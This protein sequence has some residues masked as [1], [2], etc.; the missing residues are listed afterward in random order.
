MVEILVLAVLVLAVAGAAAAWLPGF[1]RR[2]L[3]AVRDDTAGQLAALRAETVAHDRQLSTITETLD[4]RLNSIDTKVDRRF[5]HASETS[6]QIHEQ[7]GRIGQTNEQMLER[8]KDLSRLQ[9]ALRPPKARG[10]FGEHLLGN[11]L[12]DTFPRDKYQLQYTFKSGE[13]VD[14]VIR[15]DRSLVP[16][17]AKFPLD[18]FQRLVEADADAQ[19]ELHAKQ[20][21]RDVKHHVDAIAQKY[22]R[23]D[24]GT[25]EFALMYLPAEAVYYELVCGRLGGES[26]PLA[27]ALERRVIPVSP[28]TLHAYLLVL[29]LGFKGMQIEEHARGHDVRGPA[30]AGLRP[31][32]RRLRRRRQAP[33]ERAVP[34]RGRRQAAREVRAPARAGGRVGDTAGAARSGAGTAPRSGRRLEPPRSARARRSPR[35]GRGRGGCERRRRCRRARASGA[36]RGRTPRRAPRAG[37][38]RAGTSRPRP[39]H[40]RTAD[41]ARP[42]VGLRRC[43]AAPRRVRPMRPRVS[44]PSRPRLDPGARA[45]RGTGRPA[46]P[47]RPRARA[48][49]PGSPRRAPREDP[50][51]PRRRPSRPKP[52]APPVRAGARTRGGPPQG[53]RSRPSFLSSRELAGRPPRRPRGSGRRRARRCAAGTAPATTRPGRDG[54]AALRSGRRPP[55]AGRPATG[56]GSPAPGSRPRPGRRRLVRRA[57]PA[58]RDRTRARP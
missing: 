17:D 4:R 8:A 53:R 25:Y 18:N 48:R 37:F 3:G 10:G 34:V 24:E 6:R 55:P 33:R 39:P 45:P 26:S 52:G 36:A 49:A 15:L 47:R 22:I 57:A 28:S 29:V 32:P 44:R 13:R 42:A 1:L 20:F 58:A 9:E 7:L 51:V 35:A 43:R 27:Y 11:L 23:P 12:A 5:E 56:R 46:P 21:A 19:R 16:V 38:R 54:A 30:G 14:A 31:L 2:E 40:A 41:T 50:H